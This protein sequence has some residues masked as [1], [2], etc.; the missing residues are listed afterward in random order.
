M[1]KTKTPTQNDAAINIISQTSIVC[2][3][4]EV[5]KQYFQGFFWS[6]FDEHWM[7]NTH[8][9]FEFENMIFLSV[10]TWTMTGTN[11]SRMLSCFLFSDIFFLYF[12]LQLPSISSDLFDFHSDYLL[13]F[14]SS[15][16]V[17]CKIHAE[18]YD[19]KRK[20]IASF[21][22]W[23]GDEP[24]M[25]IRDNGGYYSCDLWVSSLRQ[26]DFFLISICTHCVLQAHMKDVM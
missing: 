2:D 3:V 24:S 15:N 12:D 17:F 16:T 20:R 11:M 13:L 14:H 4:V 8:V 22:Y 23:W 7:I 1:V 18:V 21:L 10:V 25:I 6:V 9:H 26:I 5:T 19:R